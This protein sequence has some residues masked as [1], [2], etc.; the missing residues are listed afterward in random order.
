VSFLIAVDQGEEINFLNVADVKFCHNLAQEGFPSQR[1][2]ILDIGLVESA[3]QRPYFH[4]TY[5]GECDIVALAAILWHGITQAH[6]FEDG[7]KRTG[8]LAMTVF[9]EANGVEL[10]EE[11]SYPGLFINARFEND[12]FTIDNLD[13][14][15]RPRCR[16][17]IE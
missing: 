7:N 8:F 2:G 11:P 12:D 3:L 4:H 1:R 6:G 9:L 10:I 5:T 14:F 16:W 13:T 15:L 17:I